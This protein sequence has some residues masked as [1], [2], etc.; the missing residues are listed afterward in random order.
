DGELMIV[1]ELADRSLQDVLEKYQAAGKPGIPR[2]ELLAYLAEAAE[3]LDLM[4][5][6][7]GL[8]HL[9]IKPP[10]LFL[11]RRQINVADF[12]LVNSLSEMNGGKVSASQLGA[13]TPLYASPESFLGKISLYSDQYSLAVTYY[14]LVTGA[15]PLEG[16]NYRQLAMAHMSA[17]PNLSRLP[18][19]DR[20]VL[21]RALAK[22]PGLRFPSCSE[23]VQALV[24][25]LQ[26]GSTP[27]EPGLAHVA[28]TS[29]DQTANEINLREMANTAVNPAT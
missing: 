23:L 3:V 8:Q 16:K 22:D 11:V 29:Q 24:Q 7:Y 25:A 4:N 5:H 12:G 15:L 9:G 17:E 26:A 10:K 27:A 20:S 19:H 21:A 13:I 28:G 1:M 6:E 18:E 14:E 2:G